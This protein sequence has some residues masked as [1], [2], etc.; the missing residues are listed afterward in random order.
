MKNV[1]NI[2]R[3]EA[4]RSTRVVKLHTSEHAMALREYRAWRL[5]EETEDFLVGVLYFMCFCKI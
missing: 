1:E 3:R 4:E 5:R 2:A